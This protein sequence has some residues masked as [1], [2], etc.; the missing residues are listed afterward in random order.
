MRLQLFNLFPA[1]PLIAGHSD[2]SY[3]RRLLAL[4]K[5]VQEQLGGNDIIVN[6]L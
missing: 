2:H 1:C 4:A 3:C 6:V 5:S